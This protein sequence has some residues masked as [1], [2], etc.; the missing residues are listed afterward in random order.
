MKGSPT[1]KTK[2]VPAVFVI[3]IAKPNRQPLYEAI[4]KINSGFGV[5][6][7]GWTYEQACKE[8]TLDEPQWKAF[9]KLFRAMQLYDEKTS[10]VICALE[11]DGLDKEAAAWYIKTCMG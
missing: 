11:M 4:G 1:A 6:E 8:N 9:H 2:E 7:T 3:K 5:V 10:R